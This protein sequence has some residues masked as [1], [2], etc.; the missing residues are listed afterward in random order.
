MKKPENK[1]FLKLFIVIIPLLFTAMT[2]NPR[3]DEG[4]YPLSEIS[5]LSLKE[6]GLK[7]PVSE[8]YNPNGTSLIDALVSTGGCTGSFVSNDGLIITN[9]HCSFDAIVQASTPENNYLE[10]G[11]VAKTKEDE[12]RTN[13]PCRITESYKDVS[14]IIL[15]AANQAK[16]VTERTTL[17]TK[18]IKELVTEEERKDSSIKANVSEMFVGKS[19]IL[20]RYKVI[21]DV[22]L[23]YAPPRNI[24]EFGGES[25]NW[26]WPRH[27]GDFSFLRAYVAPDGKP[28]KYSKDNVPYHPKKFLKVNAD[29]VKEGDFVFILGYPGRTFKHQP[30]QFLQYQEEYQLPYIQSNYSW[31]IDLYKTFG[32]NDSEYALHIAP[33]IK[34]LANTEKNYRGKLQGLKRL[35]LVEKKQTEEK[36]L[37]DFINADA[38]LK[39]EYG[40]VLYD[41]SKVYESINNTGRIPYLISLL[42]NY[43]NLYRLADIMIDYNLE[44]KKPDNE[45]KTLYTE[46]SKS[47]LISTINSQ[48]KTLFPQAD[49]EIFKKFITEALT[50]PEFKNVKA[51]EYF[52]NGN[53]EDLVNNFYE[54]SILL[55]STKYFTLLNS[56]DERINE[57]NDP[58][59]DFVSDLKETERELIKINS[60][61]QGKLNV[62]LAQF[63]DVKRMYLNKT[64]VPDANS[65]LRLTY[66][67]IKGYSPADAT[68]YSPLTSL[69]G[70]VEKGTEDGDYKINKKLVELYNNK[71]YGR[72]KDKKLNDVPVAMLYNTDTSGGNSGSPVLNAYG[73]IIGVNYDRGFE[74]TINDYAWSDDYS[75]SIGVDMRFVFWVAQKISGADNIVKEMGIKI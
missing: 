27:T 52:R 11:F 65:T 74:A 71:D 51:L 45:R 9:H 33:R 72:F 36:N 54:N 10:N 12:I 64:F 3:P 16:D 58:L 70:I 47:N 49:K 29:G 55:D 22:R 42:T 69:K 8:V 63:M 37:Q 2:M 35:Q 44:M 34:S 39:N 60:D 20:F 73:E 56:S 24:G 48:Y 62:L 17:I 40:N 14:D 30:S 75:R 66:G 61:N 50:L 53:V 23:V 67:Y 43:V 13:I 32:D 1:I 4:M 21:N 7:I 26:V 15:K 19:Y 68:Y 28:A 57:V 59:L 18:K 41:I 31:L 6:A 38:K 46:N 5:K 25:D